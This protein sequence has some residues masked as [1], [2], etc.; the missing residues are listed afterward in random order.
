MILRKDPRIMLKDYQKGREDLSNF[1]Y[2]IEYEWDGSGNP[3]ISADG[4]IKLILEAIKL[5]KLEDEKSKEKI[6]AEE[7]RMLCKWSQL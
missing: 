2:W 3:D 1:E 4:E 6:K 5:Y 7:E